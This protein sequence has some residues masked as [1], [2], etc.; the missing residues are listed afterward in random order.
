M[1][2]QVLLTALKKLRERNR[3]AQFFLIL[4]YEI[5][6]RATATYEVRV[7]HVVEGRK[8]VSRMRFVVRDGENYKA[9]DI[10]NTFEEK[11]TATFKEIFQ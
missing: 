5:D 4:D 11:F 8:R 10:V 6:G 1:D 9:H 7:D 2:V 3:A